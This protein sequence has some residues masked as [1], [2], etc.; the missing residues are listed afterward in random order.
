M[1]ALDSPGL[2]AWAE[3]GTLAVVGV[4]DVVVAH[5]KEATLVVAKD[6]AQ[7]V[8]K[9]VASLGKKKSVGKARGGKSKS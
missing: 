9:V 4:P 5:T 1:I 7:D 6:R 8:R 2:V 3:T